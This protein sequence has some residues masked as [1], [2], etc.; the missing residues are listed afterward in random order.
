MQ[1]SLA[2]RRATKWDIVKWYGGMVYGNLEP[3]T[4]TPGRSLGEAFGPF[5][6]IVEYD[7]SQKDLVLEACERKMN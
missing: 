3:P 1:A 7:D 2:R 5:Q 4:R 6:V